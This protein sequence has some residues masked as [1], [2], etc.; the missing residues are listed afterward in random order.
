MPGNKAIC[1]RPSGHSPYF[2]CNLK[3]KYWK[4]QQILKGKGYQH[5][6]KVM[7]QAATYI[8]ALPK[9]MWKGG[10]EDAT[11]DVGITHLYNLVG[12]VSMLLAPSLVVFL[13]R[14]AKPPKKPQN[15]P[16]S[17][18][19]INL[20]SSTCQSDHSLMQQTLQHNCLK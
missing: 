19:A 6:S 18:S 4:I 12:T 2:I 9:L 8:I 11:S 7:N 14:G 13:G 17:A 1:N 3:L 20:P 16:V 5:I 15:S 10:S